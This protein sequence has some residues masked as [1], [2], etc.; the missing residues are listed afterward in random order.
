MK[1][2]PKKQKRNKPMEPIKA[3]KKQ[4]ILKR[5]I[6]KF[7]LYLYRDKANGNTYA[8]YDQY[9][10]YIIRYDKKELQFTYILFKYLPI[11]KALQGG[12]IH[13]PMQYLKEFTTFENEYKERQNTLN[14]RYDESLRVQIHS[15]YID[16]K[17][18]YELERYFNNKGE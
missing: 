8:I 9:D 16:R 11:N 14:P 15:E 17:R 4:R 6:L 18:F 3:I 12:G 7:R 1:P 13:S 10:S 2:K 5:D